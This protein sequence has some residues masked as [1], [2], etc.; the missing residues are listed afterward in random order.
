METSFGTLMIGESK[1][2]V[3]LVTLNRPAAANAMNTQL[4]TEIM[5][6]FEALSLDAG[7]IRCVVVTGAGDRAF[8]AG[9]D[10]K[11]R[12]GMTDEAWAR[13]HLIYERMAR[14][15][16]SCPIPIIA[17]VNGAAYAG[18]CELAL[19][20]DFIYAAQHARFALTEVTLGIVP[21]AGGTQTLARAVGE[22]RAKE[23]VLTGKPFTA[24]EARQWG[25][26]SSVLPGSEV[27]P[28]ALA[29]AEII[30][31]NAPISVRQAKQAISRGMNMSLWDGLAL[32]IEA[33]HRTVSTE[34]RREGISSFNEKR[35]PTF[36][37][38]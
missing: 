20:C 4:G 25:M 22:R 2:Y 1:Q 34:D 24:D 7:D 8:C 6:F 12:R 5:T 30:A 29:T 17:A 10:L 11:E 35:P 32:E 36:K 9:A 28:E 15:I 21:G 33:Y 26:V 27:V 14:A 31:R 13:Q 19:A 38:R 23:I 18:G 16:L 3:M 37:G